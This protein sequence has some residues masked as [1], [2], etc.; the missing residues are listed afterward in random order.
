MAVFEK[1]IDIILSHEGGYV[2]DKDDSGGATNFGISLKFL[3]NLRKDCTA[4]DIQNLTIEEVKAIYRKEFWDKYRFGQFNNQDIATKVFDMS[5]NMGPSQA[6]KLLQR[7]CNSLTS[8]SNL[9]VDGILGK[10]TYYVTCTLNP[11]ALLNELKNQ[12]IAFYEKIIEQDPKKEKFRK[13]W[14]NR[15]GT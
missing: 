2:D 13:G 11:A 3:K 1:S 12:C 8:R 9:V 4:K 14:M 5:V 15:A 7:A 6:F 10:D